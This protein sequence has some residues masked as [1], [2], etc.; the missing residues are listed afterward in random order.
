ML[1]KGIY[2]NIISRMLEHR[3]LQAENSAL[4]CIRKNIDSAEAPKILADYLAKN[5]YEHLCDMDDVSAQMELANSLLKVANINDEFIIADK[6]RLL[7]EVLTRQSFQLQKETNAST[8]RPL[9]GFRTSN[10]FTGG[11]SNISLGEEI[12]REISS[13]DEIYLIISFLRLSGLRLIIN[14]LQKF[15]ERGDTKLRLI[16]TTYCGITDA[17]AVEQI[18]LLPNTEIRISYNTNFEKLHAKAYI[19]RRNSGLDT[20]YIGSSNLSK[21]A[22][23]DGLEWNLRVTGIENPHIIKNAL[24]TFDMY[25]SSDNFEDF[26]IGGIEKFKKELNRNKAVN[27]SAKNGEVFYPKYSILPHQ[28]QILD[29]LAVERDDL[30]NYRNLI[31]A[32]TGTGKTV[33]SAFDYRDFCTKQSESVKPRLLFTAHREEILEQALN[34][35]R[36]VLQDPNF[37][38]LWVGTSAPQEEQD[39]NQLFVS[40]SMLNSRFDNVFSKLDTNFYDFIIIDEAHHSKASSY[41]KIFNHFTP[42]ILVGLTATPERMDGQSLLPDFGNRIS[43]EIRLPQA[44]QAGLLTP[45]QYFC[46]TD[47]VDLRDSSLWQ[48]NRYKVESLAERMCVENRAQLIIDALRRYIADE[49]K[50]RALCFCVNKRHAV[51]MAEHL[52]KAGF[53][54]KSLTSDTPSDT[55]SQLL[56]D[57]EG[58]SLNYLCVVDIFNEGVDI[59]SI[60]TVLFLRPTESLT[61][62]LQQLGRGLR[63]APGKSELTVLD[64]V[65]QANHKYDFA[66]KFRALLI[67]PEKDIREQIKDGFSALPIGCSITME[68]VARS[69]ILENIQNAIFNKR[70]LIKEINSYTSIPT[71][72][73]FVKNCGIDI[74]AIYSKGRCWTSLCREAG[75]IEYTVDEISDLLKNN[76]SNLV[77]HNVVSYLKFVK[78]FAEGKQDYLEDQNSRYSLMLYYNLF[79]ER[80][81]KIPFAGNTVLEALGRIQQKP[82]EVFLKEISQLMDYN[83]DNLSIKTKPLQRELNHNLELYGCYTREEIFTLTGVQ[84]EEKRMQGSISGAVTLPDGHTILLFVTLNKSDKDF[85]PS[86]LYDD[87]VVNEHTFHWQSRNTD[88]HSNSGGKRYVNQKD[89]NNTI[90]LFV[91]ESKFDGYHNTSPFICL[92][93][94]KYVK[95]EGDLPMNITWHLPNAIPPQFLKSV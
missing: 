35:F 42:K 93:S 91:R 73:E 71:L 43:A 44:L 22:Q 94:V 45:F 95:S 32:A 54:A 49:N 15:C 87:Y 18:S 12:R 84:T 90:L 66:S 23:T 36:S 2:E 30:H 7:T 86:T 65:G 89:Q 56:K 4:K 1:K 25:W 21:S 33:I 8:V 13:A 64:F 6:D 68:K 70:R 61:I 31:V 60:D 51:F 16:T 81:Q 17:K 3:I 34:T 52:Q 19:F 85:S 53:E 67:K 26:R 77:H 46:I 41:R 62:F 83:I 57:L 27:K 14:D 79:G 47:N 48:G 55:R 9:S 80:I 69:Y 88:S 75:R 40:I 5:I 11:T 29:R 50:C 59:P 82:Y 76:I 28:K 10:L 78:N 74:R 20:A 63:L 24:A 38:T 58:G 39:F 92:G 37:G 72:G